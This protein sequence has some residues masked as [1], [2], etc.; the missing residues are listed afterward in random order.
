MVVFKLERERP[1]NAVHGNLLYYVKERYVI[2][3]ITL[4]CTIVCPT[5]ITT[6]KQNGNMMFPKKLMMY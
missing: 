5:P 6:V 1:A 3:I 4:E 2:G